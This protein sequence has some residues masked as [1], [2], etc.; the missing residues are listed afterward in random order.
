MIPDEI[1][2]DVI[3]KLQ[4]KYPTEESRKTLRLNDSLIIEILEEVE[5]LGFDIQPSSSFSTEN[6][7]SSAIEGFEY[8]IKNWIQSDN[9]NIDIVK[10]YLPTEEE[11]IREMRR[12]RV[13]I[14][15]TISKK[16]EKKRTRRR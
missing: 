10:L 16:L 2:R 14:D 11:L 6:F 5:K 3:Q 4:D 9:E 13:L 12:E 8:A 7:S 1:G 15:A